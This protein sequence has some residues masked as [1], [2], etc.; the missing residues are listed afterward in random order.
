MPPLVLHVEQIK[1]V[2]WSS[3]GLLWEIKV[4]DTH[5]VIHL[6]HVTVNLIVSFEPVTVTNE[7]NFKY[8]MCIFEEGNA[9]GSFDIS[10]K[11][12]SSWKKKK[13]AYEQTGSTP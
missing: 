7:L 9:R 4:K 2:Y 12:S 8:T 1:L 11:Y 6:H 5:V 13:K 10:D 3:S